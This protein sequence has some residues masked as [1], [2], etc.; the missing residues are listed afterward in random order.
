[1]PCFTQ[2]LAKHKVIEQTAFK[3]IIYNEMFRL[4]QELFFQFQVLL[5]PW[6]FPLPL[7]IF[8]PQFI[9]S[10]LIYSDL[11]YWKLFS[12]RESPL[13][14]YFCLKSQVQT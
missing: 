5:S 7:L 8:F 2:C 4:E 13:E 12:L 6:L 9:D 3:P 1:M 14:V 10:L 11:Q